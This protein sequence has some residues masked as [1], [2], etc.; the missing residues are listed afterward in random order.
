MDGGLVMV[1][2]VSCGVEQFEDS[3]AG[4]HEPEGLAWPVV[5]FG[6]D[7]V[8]VVL[9]VSG[10]VG[11][12]G[13]VLPE[14]PVGVLVGAAL[15]GRVR[16]AEVDLHIQCGRHTPVQGEFGSLVPC[17]RVAQEFRQRPHLADDGLLDVFGV[18]P[19]GQVQQDR[20]PGRAFH[21]RADRGP[22]GRPA[23]QVALPMARHRPVLHLGGPFADHHHGLAEPGPPRVRPRAWPACGAPAP[24]R[25]GDV[26]FQFAFGLDVDGLVDGLRAYVHALII[27]EVRP[28]PAGDLLGAPMRVQ[29]VAD[30]GE[31]ARHRAHLRGFG[32]FEPVRAHLPGPGTA[33]IRR[34]RGS[35]CGAVRG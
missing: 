3:L 21:E 16:V 7:R 27:G 19:V 2:T 4:F 25:P 33:R 12:F 15:P 14:Q 31:Q 17:Q 23:D 18:V 13:E 24:E 1:L 29:P 10:E 20:E 34:S 11:A 28:E 22:V 9:A 30:V 6:G 5:E 26:L 32:P 35:H 8:E